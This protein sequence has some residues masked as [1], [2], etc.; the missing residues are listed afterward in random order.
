MRRTRRPP[1]RGRARCGSARG[2]RRAAGTAAMPG[3]RAPPRCATRRA[4]A[5]SS[6]GWSRERCRSQAG[7]ARRRAGARVR[8]G[9]EV[10]VERLLLCGGVVGEHADEPPQSL[11][12]RL[13]VDLEL[14]GGKANGPERLSPRRTRSC[15]RPSARGTR[16]ARRTRRTVRARRSA[17][18]R[19][20][21]PPR[22]A[23]GEREARILPARSALVHRDLTEIEENPES[24]PRCRCSGGSG[25]VG[26]ETLVELFASRTKGCAMRSIGVKSGFGRFARAGGSTRP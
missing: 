5:G 20:G 11:D 3:R 6:S 15:R 12:E 18:P 1:R 13:H 9:A 8:A 10:V 17:S 26:V 24:R 16:R 4:A 19:H 14:L 2:R 21:R 23:G 22:A 7:A 25:L